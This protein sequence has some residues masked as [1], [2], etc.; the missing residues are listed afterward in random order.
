MKDIIIIGAGGVGRETALLIEQINCVKPEWKLLGF[1]DD[2][3]GLQGSLIN[4][5]KVLGKIET[6]NCYENMYTVCSISDTKIKKSVI[7]R[8]DSKIE[9]ANLIHPSAIIGPDCKMGEGIIIQANCIITTNVFL[10]NHVQ[11]NPQ[12]GIGH[13]SV[14][15][16]YCSLFWN[17]NISG[18]VNIDE[19]CILG[20]KT[21]IIQGLRIGSWSVIGSA[22]NVIRDIPSGCTAVGNPAKVIKKEV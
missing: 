13:D 22:A 16:D 15:N 4:G 3:E 2:N 21:T 5:Y 12:C 18:N 19:G 17:V 7:S 6:L 20:T 14:I 1:V 8:L 10:G 11:I 9:Y